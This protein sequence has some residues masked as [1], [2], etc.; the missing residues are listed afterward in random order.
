MP[1]CTAPEQR[2]AGGVC[3]ARKDRSFEARGVTTKPSQH[4]VRMNATRR[5][6]CPHER[7]DCRPA[8]S[9]GEGD[10]DKTQLCSWWLDAASSQ[11]AK[12]PPLCRIRAVSSD[13]ASRPK[14]LVLRRIREP[15]RTRPDRGRFHTNPHG[16]AV[17]ARVKN[18]IGRD[19]PGSF[20]KPGRSTRPPFPAPR[21]AASPRSGGHCV[22]H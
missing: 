19:Q 8:A 21:P 20:R 4:T 18:G 10:L 6:R 2:V 22:S 3:I 9:G 17:A 13:D 11:P 1:R 15:P 14:H 5:K 7:D 12:V 16:L